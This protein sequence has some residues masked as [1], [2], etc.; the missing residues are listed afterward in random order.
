MVVKYLLAWFG[1]IVL[2]VVN[3][4]L[5]DGLY[6]VGVMWLRMTLAF[7]LVMGHFIAGDPWCVVLHDY[8]ILAGGVWILIPLWVLVGPCLF[9][10]LRHGR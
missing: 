5:R 6:E 8:N 10:Q 1:M 7:E 9:F 2:A 4:G 3:G